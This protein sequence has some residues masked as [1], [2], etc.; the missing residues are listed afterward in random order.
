MYLLLLSHTKTVG[1]KWLLKQ[2]RGSLHQIQD[3]MAVPIQMPFYELFKDVPSQKE[4][5]LTA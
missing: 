3:P 5:I 2:S 1:Q 4:H